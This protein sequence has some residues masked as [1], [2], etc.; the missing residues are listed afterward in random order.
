MKVLR[1]SKGYVMHRLEKY[2]NLQERL[3]ALKKVLLDSIQG[4]ILEIK[5]VRLSCE[6]YE[7]VCQKFPKLSQAEFVIYSP[8]VEKNYHAFES[9][10]FLDNKGNEVCHI[11]GQ[12]MALYGMLEPCKEL[13]LSEEYQNSQPFV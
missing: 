9:F 1:E 5:K 7:G 10:I 4:D 8:Y 13:L 2:S 3:P 12:D 11:S 6:E